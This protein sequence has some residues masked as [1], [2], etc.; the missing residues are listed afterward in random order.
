MEKFG[1]SVL[2]SCVLLAFV[3]LLQRRRLCKKDAKHDQFVNSVQETV[4]SSERSLFPN[5]FS[6]TLEAKLDYNKVS[7]VVDA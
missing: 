2:L 5:L 4:L 6:D 3:L 7:S 1:G